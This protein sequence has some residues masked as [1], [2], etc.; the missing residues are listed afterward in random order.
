MV[1]TV[2]ACYQCIWFED[3]YSCGSIP[4][5]ELGCEHFRRYDGKRIP[6]MDLL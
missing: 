2:K 5:S 4:I 6:D 3:G 1:Y